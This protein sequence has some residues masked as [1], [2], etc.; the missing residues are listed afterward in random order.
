[1]MLYNS[2][3]MPNL[4]LFFFNEIDVDIIISQNVW[5]LRCKESTNVYCHTSIDTNLLTQKH[6]LMVIS[7]ILWKF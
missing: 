3:R 2:V 5:N 6:Q 1:M 4:L 7:T